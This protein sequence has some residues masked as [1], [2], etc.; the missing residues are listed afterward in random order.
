M[1]K[2]MSG[3]LLIFQITSFPTFVGA[4]NYHEYR[5]FDAHCVIGK[6]HCDCACGHTRRSACRY[7]DKLCSCTGTVPKFHQGPQ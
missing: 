6:G 2:L 5:K 3:S 1:R 4:T 7:Y